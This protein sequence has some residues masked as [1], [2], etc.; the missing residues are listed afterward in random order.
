LSA[1]AEF[2]PFGART[3]GPGTDREV[4]EA[5]RSP[6]TAQTSIAWI[7]RRAEEATMKLIIGILVAWV[8]VV[9]LVAPMS[10]DQSDAYWMMASQD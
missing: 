3:T 1:K 9:G 5:R 8:V 4:E 2:A 6:D 7:Y 10:A